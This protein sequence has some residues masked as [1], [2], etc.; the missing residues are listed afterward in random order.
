LLSD[1]KKFIASD[2]VLNDGIKKWK[3][4]HSVCQNIG[5]WPSNFE[6]KISE[7]DELLADIEQYE[8]YIYVKILKPIAIFVNSKIARMARFEPLF[9]SKATWL[10][11]LKICLKNSKELAEISRVFLGKEI[12]VFNANQFNDMMYRHE[13]FIKDLSDLKI[14]Q[15][16]FFTISKFIKEEHLN[17]YVEFNKATSKL[18][19]EA[20][21]LEILLEN[22]NDDFETDQTNFLLSEYQNLNII[23]DQFLLQKSAIW[24]MDQE[25]LNVP[26]HWKTL[27]EEIVNLPGIKTTADSILKQQQ[28][29]WV[30]HWIEKMEFRQ[31]LLASIDKLSWLSD[32]DLLRNSI[33]EKRNLVSNILK[34]RLTERTYNNLEVNRLGNRLTYRNLYHQVSK[35]RLKAPLR[36]LWL[37]HEDEIKR[38]IPAWLATPESVSATW[39]ISTKFDL[40]IFDESSQCFAERGIPAAY[41]AKQ[42]VIVGDDKQLPPNQLFTTRWEEN[43]SEEDAMFFE[44]NSLLDLGQQFLPQSL[45]KGHYRSVF[46]ELISFSNEYFYDGK[47]EFLPDRQALKKRKPALQWIKVDGN[48]L[49]QQN[50]EEAKEIAKSIF[51][52]IDAHPQETLG[53]ITFNAKQQILIEKEIEIESVAQERIVPDWLFVKNIENVQ[54]D[55]RDHIWFSIAYARNEHNKIVAQFGTLSQPGGENR[56][57]VAITRAKKSITVYSSILPSELPTT[58]NSPEGPKLLKKYLDFVFKSSQTDLEEGLIH[59]DPNRIGYPQMDGLDTFWIFNDGPALYDSNS[60]KD[61]FAYKFLTLTRKG[62]NVKYEFSR[63]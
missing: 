26:K 33:E 2:S 39:P 36:K 31:P 32:L 61:Y 20:V 22:W 42:I 3:K 43:E 29:S 24:N 48:W 34:L 51:S 44:Q 7:I 28:I 4:I 53:I 52:F 12:E 55:E 60:M 19:K 30:K 47:L 5:I 37:D 63:R 21:Q 18:G 6:I 8:K 49:N 15:N 58:E 27:A 25:F 13:Q 23:I 17:S 40:V 38:I 11:D 46:P 45:L 16:A 62:F 50:L 1:F 56:L 54:G 14:H 57:N 35:K 9:Q 59:F 41:R 10:E